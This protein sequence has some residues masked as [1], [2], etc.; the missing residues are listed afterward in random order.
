MIQFWYLNHVLHRASASCDRI[1]ANP[2]INTRKN[3]TA[4]IFPRVG[5]LFVKRVRTMT[6]SH[7]TAI[8]IISDFDHSEKYD[9]FDMSIPFKTYLPDQRF[10]FQDTAQQM[11]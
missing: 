7:I 4:I 10:P 8:E 2:P 5:I 9:Y 11:P 6:T 3:N 1:A